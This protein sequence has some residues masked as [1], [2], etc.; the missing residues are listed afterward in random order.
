MAKATITMDDL[1][2]GG[3]AKQL[4]VG[5][6][7]T[8][9]V[10]SVRK[11][12][13]LIDLGAHG[14][15]YVPRREVG[16]GRQLNVGDEVSASVIDSELDNGYSLLSLRKAAK[17]RGWEEIQT[18][19]D[20]GEIVEITPYDANRGGLLVEYEGV[21]GFLPVSQLSAEHYPRVGSADKDEI[22]ASTDWPTLT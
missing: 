9:H 16:F 7:V 8:G 19:F 4:V 13:V 14:V 10:L 18:R 11:H 21:R 3:D 22:L 12:E 20:A 6:M 2:A 17:D 5:E 1:L 15:G